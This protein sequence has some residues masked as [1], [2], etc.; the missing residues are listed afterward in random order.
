MYIELRPGTDC[1]VHDDREGKNKHLIVLVYF[2][3]GSPNTKCKLKEIVV[4]NANFIDCSTLTGG[5]TSLFQILVTDDSN[6]SQTSLTQIQYDNS[7][8]AS[9]STPIAISYS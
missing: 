2:T 3:I 1:I 5:S 6:P 8:K 7:F 4:N 9:Y